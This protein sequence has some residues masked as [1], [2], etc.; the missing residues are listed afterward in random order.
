MSDEELLQQ[1][2]YAVNR[3]I[4]HLRAWSGASLTA[5]LIE[6]LASVCLTILRRP[7]DWG[8]PTF[9]ALAAVSMFFY[10][11]FQESAARATRYR[12][13]IMRALNDPAN[14]DYYLNNDD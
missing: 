10:K 6:A 4:S 1:W 8:P 5:A 9:M 11:H 3:Q 14:R 12:E 2:L 13:R 7:F